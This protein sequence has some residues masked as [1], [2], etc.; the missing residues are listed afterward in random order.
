[1]VGFCLKTPK[2][3]I[4]KK[5]VIN[6]W[7]LN[8]FLQHLQAINDNGAPLLAETHGEGAIGIS[9]TRARRWHWTVD[10]RHGALQF[11][12]GRWAIQP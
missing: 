3:Q 4:N 12:W 2:L 7:I 1:L 6:H 11:N 5:Q 10:P 9:S 8:V